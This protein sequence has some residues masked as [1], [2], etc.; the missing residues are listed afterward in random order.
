MLSGKQEGWAVSYDDSS[1]KYHLTPSG[2]K[3]GETPAD[4]AET[5][6]RSSRQASGWSREYVTWSCVWAN[7]DIPG[8]ERDAIRVKHKDFMGSGRDITIGKPL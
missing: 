6:I 1:I 3:P 7:P 4:C 5:W 2:W 8:P